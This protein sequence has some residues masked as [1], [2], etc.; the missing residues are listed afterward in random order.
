M[1]KKYLISTMILFWVPL[2]E[3]DYIRFPFE[4]LGKPPKEI[5]RS[6]SCEGSIESIDFLVSSENS[7][8]FLKISLSGTESPRKKIVL[9][10]LNIFLIDMGGLSSKNWIDLR[11]KIEAVS[12]YLIRSRTEVL[13]LFFHKEVQWFMVNEI[14]MDSFLNSLYSL[15]PGKESHL[16]LALQ[17]LD[18]ILD[19]TRINYSKALL[20]TDGGLTPGVIQSQSLRKSISK[21]GSRPC[22]LHV[23]PATKTTKRDTLDKLVAMS[24]HILWAS[25]DSNSNESPLLDWLSKS[26]RE[27]RDLSLEFRFDGPDLIDNSRQH[28]FRRRGATWVLTQSSEE[29]TQGWDLPLIS[30]SI[31]SIFVKLNYQEKDSGIERECVASAS[32]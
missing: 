22:K 8:N 5:S 14:S 19:S 20:I 18:Q 3:A 15:K 27:I 10:E 11:S 24:S 16:E 21:I 26:Q 7:Q 28:S 31:P 29:I 2:L 17:T 25:V 30:R 1:V 23:L 9:D 4:Y 6:I 12:R 32:F 13:F